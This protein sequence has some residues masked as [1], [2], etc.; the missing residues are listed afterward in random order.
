MRTEG[1]K[2][3]TYV[4]NNSGG[5]YL[6]N[7]DVQHYV[8]IEGFDLWQIEAMANKIFADYSEYCKCCGERWSTWKGERDMTDKPIISGYVVGEEFSDEYWCRDKKA[9]IYY[10]NGTKEIVDLIINKGE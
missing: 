5:Y 2:F 10:L 4:Q 1:T 3:I 6:R 8:I 9:I 7:E